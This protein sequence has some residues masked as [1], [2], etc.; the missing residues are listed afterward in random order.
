VS[1]KR[2]VFMTLGVLCACL[3]PAVYAWQE[4]QKTY[5][6][7]SVPGRGQPGRPPR[8]GAQTGG[9]PEVRSYLVKIGD[10]K[11]L[12]HPGLVFLAEGISASGQASVEVNGN[13]YEIPPAPGGLLAKIIVP[14]KM[15]HLIAGLNRLSFLKGPGAGSYEVLDSRIEEIGGG[16]ARIAG[17]TYYP[18]RVAS[19]LTD[20][21]F[22]TTYN[23]ES[24]RKESELADFAKQGKTRF[25]RA[26]IDFNHLD[27]M[28]ELFKEAHVNL[29]MIQIPTPMDTGS[30]EYRTYRDLIERFHAAGIKVMYDGGN[31]SQPV[32]LNSISL[33]SI[34]LHP[35]QREWI[36]R[37]EYGMPRWRNAGRTFWPDLKNKDYRNEVVKVADVAMGAGVDAFYFDWAIGETA[38]LVRLFDDIRG[39]TRRRGKNIPIYGNCKGNLPVEEFCDATKSEGTEEAGVWDGKWVHNVSQAR[40]YYA[41]GDGWKPYESKYE[42]ADPGAPNPGAHDVRDGMK[43]G[44]KR[45]IAEAAAFQSQFALA[46]AGNR[47]FQGWV[48]KN[49]DLAM[50]IWRDISRYYAFLAENEPLYTDVAAVS[51]IAL[52]APPE[53]PS[54][55]ARLK[56]GPLYDALAELN[57]MYDVVLLTRLNETTLA[58]YKTVVIPDLPWVDERQSRWLASYRKAGGQILTVGSTEE[59]RRISSVTMPSSVCQEI[60]KPAV[61]EEFSRNL[62]KLSGKPRVAIENGNYV[63]ANLVRKRGT[64]KLVAHFVNYGE[65][66]NN[67]AV[68]LNLEGAVKQVN[69][70]SIRL[71]SPDGVSKQ[72]AGISVR[73]MEV[74]FTLPRLEVYDVVIIN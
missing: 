29:V 68:Q 14:L 40:F 64:E 57:Q 20:F 39:V 6:A 73:G 7:I 63:I 11:E 56:R 51:D 27:R 60:R 2:T 54:F 26:G 52:L 21:D 9:T 42:G 74:S 49:N 17:V 66:A 41:A 33:E 37:D 16:A 69:A 58:R 61:R 5:Q 34:L 62:L 59:L 25:Y 72:I 44:W 28:F 50:D 71:L 35:E 36:G 31:G 65:S 23:S 10:V 43:C 4:M 67:V 19:N 1:G 3:A 18:R 22:V 53:I 32:R 70:A 48:L 55:E 12:A 24:R 8:N 46:E 15:E 47:L 45:P 13:A 30:T 38:D